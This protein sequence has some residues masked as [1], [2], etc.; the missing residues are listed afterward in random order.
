M[1]AKNVVWVHRFGDTLASYRYR[2][3][4]PCEQVAKINGYK[5]AMNDGEADIVVFSK[6]NADELPIARQAKADGA[7]IVVDFADDHFQRDD[8][9]HQFAEIADGIVCASDIMRGRI[10]D[11]VKRDSV[12]IPDPYEY[13]EVAPHADGDNYLWYGHVGNFPELISV[14]GVLGERKLRVVSGP[15]QIPNV[16]RWSKESMVKAFQVSNIVILPTRGAADF[17]SANRLINAIRSGCFAVCMAHPSYKEFK[18]FVWVG[19]FPT[20]LKWTEHFRSELNER[21]SAGQAYVRKKYSPEAIGALWA[22]Y[23][24]SV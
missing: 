12:S 9:Y 13:E 18:D 17:K 7:K 6:P 2:A 5:T 4:I 20:G 19:N 23:L 8:T 24:E 15:Q 22:N 10:Y 16:I 11:Y 3:Q 21:V 14:M 1:S